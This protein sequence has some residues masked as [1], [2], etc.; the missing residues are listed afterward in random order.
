MPTHAAD[1]QAGEPS[2]ANA[3]A[4]VAEGYDAVYADGADSPALQDIWLRLACGTDFPAE[5]SHISFLTL[6]EA[7]R[8][9]HDSGLAED[10]RL[11]DLACGTGG[12]GLLIARETGAAL[13]GIDISEVGVAR[14]EARSQR[15][16]LGGSAEFRV[17]S[18]EETGLPD[19]F[20]DAALT[21]D[22]L[23]YST[24]K[25]SALRE[26]ARVLRPGSRLLFTAFEVEPAH[27]QG[28]PVL[29]L[30]PVPDYTP[31]LSE[32]G[33]TV[34]AYEETAGWRERLTAAYQAVLDEP[35]SLTDELG[36]KGY[37]SLS[38]EV[39]VTLG[40]DPYRRRVLGVAT[41]R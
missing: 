8:I 33:F 40:L 31:L 35:D 17:G 18:F 19:L 20:A 6:A 26:I 5:F 4:L 7:Q 16:G 24:D 10:D 23:Q 41:R 14:A 36:E 15:V 22:A 29:G 9:A 34:D 2:A 1:A 11:V 27:V 13:T 39:A 30:D 38:L 32:V 37:M 3:R 21:V 25:R 28:Y 12:P